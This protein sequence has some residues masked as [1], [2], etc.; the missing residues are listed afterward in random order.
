MLLAQI[1]WNDIGNLYYFQMKAQIEILE[2]IGRECYIR[3]PKTGTN[4]RG[5]E[6]TGNAINELIHHRL[7]KKIEI[8][9]KR[10]TV[11]Y[12]SYERWV[13]YWEQD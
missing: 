1:C 9:W 8:E 10:E 3:L 2:K 5:V 12:N 13:D 4:Q 6:L 7:T 11:S